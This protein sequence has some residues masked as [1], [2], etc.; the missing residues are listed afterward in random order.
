MQHALQIS[1]KIEYGTRAMAY[2]ASLPEGMATSFREIA[3][4]MDVPGAFL[5]K[6][7]KTLVT[8]ELVKSTRGAHGGYSLA[9]PAQRI[10]FLDIIEAV[11]G[12]VGVNVCTS[13]DAGP[14]QFTGMCTLHQVWR[15]GQ[16]QMLDVYRSTTLDRLAMRSLKHESPVLTARR[17]G[18]EPS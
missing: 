15:Q 12:S 16:A 3:R 6:I 17:S 14:C 18:D 11:E 2:M 10:T 9:R 13:S 5:A 7:L 1:R 4:K 8:A